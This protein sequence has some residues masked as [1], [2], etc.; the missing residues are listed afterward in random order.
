MT[1][2]EL[3]IVD[4]IMAYIKSQESISYYDLEEYAYD[5]KPEWIPMFQKKN[6]RAFLSEYLRSRRRMKK[7]K[8]PRDR[9]DSM[10][11]ATRAKTR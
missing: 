10:M 4:E 3:K 11:A 5:N 6:Y 7:V 9:F 2:E 1:D 8:Y